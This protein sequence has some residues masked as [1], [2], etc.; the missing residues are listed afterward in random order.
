MYRCMGVTFNPPPVIQLQKGVR[1]RATRCL[2]LSQSI[3]SHQFAETGHFPAGNVARVVPQT[4]HVNFR[5]VGQPS[6]T[7]LDHP[8]RQP[9][10]ANAR[11]DPA[12]RPPWRQPRGKS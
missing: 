3:W 4:Q 2:P 6:E 12:A 5:I 8:H 11:R 9:D 1:F 10:G 7:E